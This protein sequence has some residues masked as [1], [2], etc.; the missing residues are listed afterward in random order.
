MTCNPITYVHCSYIWICNRLI[1]QDIS[2][3]KQLRCT[4]PNHAAVNIMQTMQQHLG[5]MKKIIMWTNMLG[6]GF[7]GVHLGFCWIHETSGI[8]EPPA[9]YPNTHMHT[10]TFQDLNNELS[11]LSH[12][13]GP[14]FMPHPFMPSHKSISCCCKSPMLYALSLHITQTH[15]VTHRASVGGQVKLKDETSI[16]NNYS[17]GLAA[18]WPLQYKQLLLVRLVQV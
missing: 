3:G 6:K 17:W 1:F 18:P 9:L 12:T 14:P 2:M 8:P 4:V 11:C 13:L 10:H 15:N 5:I 7:V 16:E